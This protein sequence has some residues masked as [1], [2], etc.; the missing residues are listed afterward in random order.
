MTSVTRTSLT[1]TGEG[2]GYSRQVAP[3][4]YVSPRRTCASEG[5]DA[6]RCHCSLLDLSKSRAVACRRDAGFHQSHCA[7]EGHPR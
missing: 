7:P 4:D 6:A 2:W 3:L 5:L 1:G